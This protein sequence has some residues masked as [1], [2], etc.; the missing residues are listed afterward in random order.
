MTLRQLWFQLDTPLPAMEIYDAPR[1]KY[2]GIL[3]DVARHYLTVPQIKNFIDVM[4]AAKLNTLHWHLSDDEAFRVNLPDFPELA[5]IG[6]ARGLNNPIGPMSMMQKNLSLASESLPN[7][8]QIYGQS[9]TPEQIKDLVNYANTREITIIPEIDIPGHSRALMKALPN[10]FYEKGDPSEYAGYGD[11]VLP[12]CAYNDLSKFGQRFK[13][14]LV[15][16]MFQITQL[17]NHQTTPYAIDNELSIGGDEVFKGTWD[18]SPSC[19]KAP[20]NKFNTRDKEHYFL[21]LFNDSAKINRLKLSG[22]HEFVIDHNGKIDDTN[23]VDASEIGHVWVWSSGKEAIKQ[24]VTLANNNFPVVMDYAGSLYFDMAYTPALSEPGFYWSTRFGDTYAALNSGIK[25][26]STLSQTKAPQNILGL[27]GTLWTDVI[28]DYAQLQYM[29]FPKIAGLSE[30]AW[31]NL[32]QAESQP[33]WQS[34][35]RRLGCGQSGFLAYLHSA[36]NVT[37][38]GY[39]NGIAKEAPQLCH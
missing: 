16:I 36:Y 31:S 12:V 39:P 28:P 29:A 5:N 22:W 26:N 19:Q 33:N 10:S 8:S 15:S 18:N 30:A 11:D 13:A 34:L 23:G 32:N 17:F 7:A 2:R 1:F 9:Y 35:A 37:Y 4:A 20:W 25:A 38:R 24:A 6:A 21:D 14:D 27:E 3:L